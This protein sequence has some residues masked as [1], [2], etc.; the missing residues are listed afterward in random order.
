[1]APT[2]AAAENIGGNTCHLA[3]GIKASKK[4]NSTASFHIKDLWAGKT[5]AFWYYRVG[6]R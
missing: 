4:Q 3:F 1:M 6:S 5:I 2:G